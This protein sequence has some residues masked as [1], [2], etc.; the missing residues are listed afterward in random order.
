MHIVTLLAIFAYV[1]YRLAYI[2]QISI[3]GMTFKLA[4]ISERQHLV[5]DTRRITYAQHRHSV[6]YK[7]FANPVD[8]HIALGAYKHLRFSAQSFINSLNKRSSFTCSRRTMHHSHI[9]RP[10][11]LIDSL[12]LS[13]IQPRKAQ[14]IESKFLRLHL[15]CKEIAQILKAIVLCIYDIVESMKHCSVTGLIKEQLHSKF[16]H[17]LNID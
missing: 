11:H 7:L 13:C 15:S 14:R 4:L 8:S 9:L 12:F 16:I 10:Q 6:V 2:P 3:V 1:T 5:V 17:R